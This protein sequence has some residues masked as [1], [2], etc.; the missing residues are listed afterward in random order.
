VLSSALE[1]A[2]NAAWN[3]AKFAL[4]AGAIAILALGGLIFLTLAA[5]IWAEG[6][7]GALAAAA[8]L[9]AVFLVLALAFA[10]LARFQSRRSYSSR[11][12]S[13]ALQQAGQDRAVTA[14]LEVLRLLGPKNVFP[15]LALG[16]VI[17][18]AAQAV[19]RSKSKARAAE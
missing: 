11:N 6:A 17:L 1:S 13:Q 14:A 5:F 9:R 2:R 4:I 15:A 12:G 19:P 10:A 3:A 7:Y 16:A 18:A 8:G